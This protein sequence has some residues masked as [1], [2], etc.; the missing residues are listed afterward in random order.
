LP[1]RRV[2]LAALAAADCSGW[3]ASAFEAGDGPG[4]DG[5]RIGAEEAKRIGLVN[6]VVPRAELKARASDVAEMIIAGAPLAIERRSR[7]CCRA[8]HCPISSRLARPLSGAER[9]LE[10]EDA[11]EGQRAFVE[12][13]KPVW[14]GDSALQNRMLEEADDRISRQGRRQRQILEN[15]R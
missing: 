8:C 6:D 2:G 7:S 3:R 12:K 1:E 9:M 11:K 14:Q 4:S 5:R 10:S 13:R 15:G